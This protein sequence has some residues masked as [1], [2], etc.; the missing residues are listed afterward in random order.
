MVLRDESDGALR[1]EAGLLELGDNERAFT[2]LWDAGVDVIE[3][4]L[5]RGGERVTLGQAVGVE[6][7]DGEFVTHE[8]L[9]SEI[10]HSPLM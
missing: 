5:E 4:S 3:Q 2:S 9:P 6:A 10:E 1:K 7:M 8:S